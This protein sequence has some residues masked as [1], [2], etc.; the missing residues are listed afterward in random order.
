METIFASSSQVKSAIRIIRISGP[1]ARQIPKIFKFCLTE[2]KK[3]QL[4]KLIFNNKVIDTAPVV[5]LPGP[6]TYTGEDIY[7]LHVHGSFAIEQ[8]IYKALI[9]KRG[10]RI[11]DKGEFTRQ[12]LLNGRMDLTQAE[13]VNDIVN[14]E[15][16]KQLEIANSNIRGNLTKKIFKWRDML[17]NNIVFVETLIDFSDEDI[18]ENLEKEFY[19]KLNFLKNQIEEV[20]KNS[21][22]SSNLKNGFQVLIIGKTNVGKSSLMNNI[23]N[24]E[25]SIVTNIPGTTRDVVEQKID[26]YGYP[27]YFVDS[28]GLRKTKSRVELAGINKTKEKILKSDIIVHL[29]DDGNFE[30]PIDSKNLNKINVR[31]KSD[32][33]KNRFKNE[34]VS[35]SIKEKKGINKLLNMIF[36]KIKKIEP[37]E[38]VFLTSER[39]IQFGRKTLQVLE[40]IRDLSIEEETELVAEELR[41]AVSYIE[42]ITSVVDIEDV[43]D[44]IF[45]KFCI[46]K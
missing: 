45:S 33:N 37:K 29:S 14:A 39:Q 28:A 16:E 34:E 38:S 31:S 21:F 7:E 32:I 27:V 11:A 17:I 15:T 3:F 46:G 2:P 18:P 42:G 9:K 19:S 36:N 24:N 10:F 13:A 23:M 1:K 30:L 5:W 41:L 43:L 40:R 26:L 6:H 12:A 25:V 44:E 35:I 20:I 22:Y 8:A 4:K